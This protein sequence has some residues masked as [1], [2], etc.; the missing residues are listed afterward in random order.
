[1]AT[2]FFIDGQEIIIKS[3]TICTWNINGVA[4]KLENPTV[5][6]HLVVSDIIC[7]NETKT[8]MNFNIAGY[9]TYVSHGE[10]SHRGG[11]GVLIRSNLSK[12]VVLMDT[13]FPDI[14]HFRLKNYQSY[15]FI[16]AYIPPKD[17]PYFDTK[18]IA[19]LNAIIMSNQDRKFVLLGDLNARYANLRDIF[20]VSKPPMMNLSYMAAQDQC[21]TPNENAKLLIGVLNSLVLVNGLKSE[22]FQFTNDL[23][24]RQRK[25]WVSELD[26]VYVSVNALQA[27]CDLRVNQSQLPSN[28]AP[29]F[30][31]LRTDRLSGLDPDDL[32]IRAADLGVHDHNIPNQRSRQIKWTSVDPAAFSTYMETNGPPDTTNYENIDS[33]FEEADGIVRNGLVR[34]TWQTRHNAPPAENDGT[35][36]DRWQA[37][38]DNNDSRKLWQNI[39][40]NG[41]VSDDSGNKDQ[42][43]DDQFRDHFENLLNPPRVDRFP[44]ISGPYIPITDD[45][46][47]P[48][49]VAEALSSMKTNRSGGPSGIPPGMFR[50]LPV[51]WLLF[52]ATMFTT[53]MYTA[54]YP[55]SWAMSRLIVIFKKG[56]RQMCDNYRGISIMDSWAKLYDHLLCKRLEKWF[57]P[58]REQAGAQA[59]RG[60]ME[61]ILSLRLLYDYAISRKKKLYVIFV[62]FSKAY[63]KVPRQALIKLLIKLGCGYFMTVALSY[64]YQD[65]QM[66][67]GMAIISASVGLRQGAPTSCFLFT[68]YLDGFVKNLKEIAGTDGFLSWV[69]TLLLMDDTVIFATTRENAIEKA[70]VLTD[71]C[72]QS[73]MV[74]N[75]GKTK[76][77]VI[78][79]EQNDVRPLTVDDLVIQNCE[80]YNYLGCIFTQDGK[81]DSTVKSHAT[82][83]QPHIMKFVSFLA[84]NV[85]FPFWVKRKVLEAALLSSVLYGC[86]SWIRNSCKAMRTPY[87]TAVKTLLGVRASTPNDMCLIELN[88]PSLDARVKASQKCFLQKILAD[89]KGMRDDP[90]MKIWEICR[91]S[92]TPGYRYLMDVLEGGDHEEMDRMSRVERVRTNDGSKFRYYCDANPDLTEHNLYK[93]NIPEYQRISFSRLRL[94]SHRLAIETGRW[95]RP[96]TPRED[97]LCSCGGVQTEEHIITEC[98]VTENIRKGYPSADFTSIACFFRNE[99]TTIGQVAWE[100]LNCY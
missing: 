77:M 55:A 51:S 64:L 93:S 24:Y 10:A 12:S 11:C 56:Q 17:S 7:L 36:T 84:K 8:D 29:V 43:S 95:T 90:F 61:H 94:S 70:R 71:F 16:A 63:D 98:E 67:L 22:N 54:S 23:T 68:M 25:G 15:D 78:R 46:F 9:K 47:S 6:S 30:L 75:P 48:R 34:S 50:V 27:V 18:A 69:H 83:K 59:G 91:D 52:I 28:H 53:I 76:F 79:G 40:W 13:S 19:H 96:P 4:N 3:L 58:H 66:I 33:V 73:G 81:A 32:V 1:M 62:D 42:P 87:L 82:A 60:C 65:T 37:L 86:E 45:P 2:E 85:D 97:R 89:R 99:N 35:N 74:I 21:K 31:Q 57:R 72:R 5:L 88:M 14:I 39:N 20:L 41:T 44:V 26:H 92:E 49:E 38:A 80:E 100:C